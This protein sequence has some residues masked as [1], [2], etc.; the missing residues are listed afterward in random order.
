[1]DKTWI[2]AIE[3]SVTEQWWWGAGKGWGAKRGWMAG[4]VDWSD[5]NLTQGIT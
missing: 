2:K 4:T 3:M 5:N 1:M